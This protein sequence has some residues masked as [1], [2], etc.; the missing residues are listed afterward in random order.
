MCDCVEGFAGDRCDAC[1][2]LSSGTFPNCQPCDECTTQW[3]DRILPLEEQVRTTVDFIGSL[4]LT[5]ETSVGVAPEIDALF[6]LVAEIRAVLNMS[7]VDL[8]ASDVNSTHSLICSLLDRTESLLQRARQAEG[9][10]G[11]LES[12]STNITEQLAVLQSTLSQLEMEFSNISLTFAQEDF[13]SVNYTEFL[14]LARSALERS[15]LANSIIEEDVAAL[16]NRTIDTLTTYNQT[17]V[18]SNFDAT[19]TA[20]TNTLA[21]IEGRVQVFR[22]F[23]TESNR[24]LCGAANSTEVNCTQ[25][26]GG[27]ACDT[28]GGDS[29]NSLYTDSI[30]ALNNSQTAVQLAED[31]LSRIQAQVDE[32]RSFLAEVELSQSSAIEVESFANATREKAEG[33]LR[34]LQSL[35]SQVEKELNASRID[36]DEI[37]RRENMTLSLQLDLLPEEV[38]LFS[39]LRMKF[40]CTLF[41]SQFLDLLIEINSTIGG[42]FSQANVS[43]EDLRER[44]EEAL[45]RAL[46]AE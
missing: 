35:V 22:A 8:L 20:I 30:T 13:S 27:L 39:C 15:D 19:Q 16:I 26:C 29:C 17:L 33:L 25:Q 12:V 7:M 5:N 44:V 2:P 37:G 1:A 36:P 11:Y 4:N 38:S 43:E 41:F 31:A 40:H 9:R 34:D 32:L 45:Q 24:A 10:I 14:Q 3:E 42:F 28:C 23:I 46:R 6:E 18:S 21:T